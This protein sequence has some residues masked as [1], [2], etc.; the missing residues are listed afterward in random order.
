[1]ENSKALFFGKNKSNEKIPLVDQKTVTPQDEKKNA[2]LLNVFFSSAAKN[3][4][5]PEFSVLI[6]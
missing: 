4:K 6:P 3:L 5:I 2:E 1:M